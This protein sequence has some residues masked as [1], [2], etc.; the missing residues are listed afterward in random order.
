MLLF[1]IRHALTPVTGTR[2]ASRAPGPHLSPKGLDQAKDMAERMDKVHLDAVYSSALYR[3]METAKPLAAA[4]R[5]RLRIRDGLE[6]THYGEWE[7]R[8]LKQLAA[9]KHWRKVLAHPSEGRFPGGETLAETQCRVLAVVRSIAADHP[10]ESVAI[11]SHADPIRLA[12]AHFAGTHVDHFQ[13]LS[14]APASVSAVW[15]SEGSQPR[16]LKVNS[17]GTL[18]ELSRTAKR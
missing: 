18:D 6:D 10:K 4:K 2:L 17:T 3:A 7:G 11:V 1:L 13:R 14:I 16:I 9:T 15:L 8:A 5:L 12:I